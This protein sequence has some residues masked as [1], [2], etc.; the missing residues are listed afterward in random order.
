MAE[1]RTGEGSGAP[2]KRLATR[3]GTGGAAHG[4]VPMPRS[5]YSSSSRGSRAGSRRSYSQ[6]P[7]LA[8]LENAPNP[9]T[10]P[11]DEVRSV[12]FSSLWDF[13]C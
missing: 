4:V 10:M 12:T 13:S 1:V 6:H 11:S 9:F 8:D 7:I 5:N 3:E 2:P